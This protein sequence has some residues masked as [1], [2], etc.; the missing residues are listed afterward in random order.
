MIDLLGLVAFTTIIGIGLLDL[1]SGLT[2]SNVP[3]GHGDRR[4]PAGSGDGAPR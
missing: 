3:L 1:K 4:S 2:V